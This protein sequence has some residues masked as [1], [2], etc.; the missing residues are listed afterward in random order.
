MKY[1]ISDGF[2]YYI[3]LAGD[4]DFV[5]LFRAKAYRDTLASVTEEK[6]TFRYADG[7]WSIKQLIGH[8]TDH[9]RI[10]TY[11]TMR[12]SRKDPTLLPGYEQDLM[13][14][15]GRFDD[16][17]FS[18]LM[19]DLEQVRNATLTFIASLSAE[20]LSINRQSLDLRVNRGGLFEGYRG[21]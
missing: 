9:E 11:R 10:M 1:Q 7:K 13:V 12:F 17:S 14:E 2:P 8:I 6:S 3:E 20:Q 21:A 15:N 19:N 16:Q 18:Q 4:E 5:Q